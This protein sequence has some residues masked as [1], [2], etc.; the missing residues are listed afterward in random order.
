MMTVFRS[1]A[2]LAWLMDWVLPPM[3]AATLTALL[4]ASPFGFDIWVASGA[5]SLVAASSYAVG[6]VAAWVL[7]SPRLWALSGAL[8]VFVV[9]GRTVAH[10]EDELSAGTATA[11]VLLGAER[12]LLA[13]L[14]VTFHGL[15]AWR[16]GWRGQAGKPP[17]HEREA[18]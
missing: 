6:V 9:G 8:S 7:R 17:T 3:I 10:V 2:A 13:S 4:A 15:Q 5:V 1:D 18:P 14:L 16:I 11:R 12:V